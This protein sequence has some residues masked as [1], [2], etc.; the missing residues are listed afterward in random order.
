MKL[1][2]FEIQ[3]KAL[4]FYYDLR[5][6]GVKHHLALSVVI[7]FVIAL[8]EETKENKDTEE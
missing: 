1:E 6:K 2:Y 8:V 5:D 3:K 4:A 7:N